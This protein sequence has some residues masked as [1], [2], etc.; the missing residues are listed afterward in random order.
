MKTKEKKVYPNDFKSLMG[1]TLPNLSYAF[2]GVVFGLFFQYI[3]DYSGIDEAM[4]VSGFAVAFGTAFLVVSRIVDAVDDPLQAWIMDRGKEKKF[5]KYR[6]FTLFSQAFM[7]VGITGLFFIPHFVKAN[8]I[9]LWGWVLL[10]YI[11]MEVGS[12]FN[13]LMPIL[14]KATTDFPTRSKIMTWMRMCMIIGA[15]PASLAVPIATMLNAHINN[16]GRSVQITVL[17]FMIIAVSI[18]LLG[19]KLLH[20]PF[21]QKKDTKE[22]ETALNFKDLKLMV[23]T[24][25]ALWVH[26]FAY[27]IGTASFGLMSGMMIYYLKWQYTADLSTGVVDNTKYA[28]IYGVSSVI[29]LGLGF[30][31]PILANLFV[32]KIGK[33]D[34]AARLLMLTASIFY[35]LMFVLI[36]LGV[37][38]NLPIVYV[39]LNALAGIPIS[40]AT[41]PFLLLNVEVADFTEYK[42]GKNM[43]ATTTSVNKF[44][45]KT[46]GALTGA[47]TGF[48]LILA[49]YSVNAQTGAYAGDLSK[50]P[51]MIS[52]FELFVTVIPA[53]LCLCCW[54][55]YRFMYPITPE[56]RAEMKKTL[57]E[58]HDVTTEN[59]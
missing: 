2:T 18:S 11:I 56:I 33:V 38:A 57:E 12:A 49:G 9:L 6:F 4:G 21:F 14:Q 10:S 45:E 52:N 40:M 42:T 8:V 29:S 37:L 43:T 54:A 51:G 32:K 44:L 23:K 28:A 30:V 53:I 15:V 24:N 58:K 26:N 25:K 41:I 17:F 3:T 31:A 13:G 59:E 35:F 46:V 34:R 27:V 48:V 16:M 47:A 5:G 36:R 1:F 50:I 55:I 22:E 39:V 7:L 19:I 20:E